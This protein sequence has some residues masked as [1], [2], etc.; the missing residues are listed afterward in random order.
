[1]TLKRNNINVIFYLLTHLTNIDQIDQNN[2]MKMKCRNTTVLLRTH[3]CAGQGHAVE[4]MQMLINIY[5]NHK[6]QNT[7]KLVNKI[8]DYKSNYTNL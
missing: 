8:Y 5:N 6:K 2:T 7:L 4:A 3:T 1:M